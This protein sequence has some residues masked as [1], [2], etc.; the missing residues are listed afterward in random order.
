MPR[1]V[2]SSLRQIL[3]WILFFAFNRLVFILY[4]LR[5]IRAA[6]IS[7][8]EVTQS[9]VAA[10]PLDLST[11][12]YFLII[13]LL[14]LIVQSLFSPPW[15]N[16]LN[17]VYTAI[18]IS[19]YS[20]ITVAEL[21]IYEE[22][23]TKLHYKAL[24][25]LKNPG[26]IYNSAQTGTFFLLLALFAVLLF[27]G[28]LAY[29]RWF[30]RNLVNTGSN[31]LAAALFL[32]IAPVLLFIGMRGGV[33]EIP[34]SQSRSF[35]SR[36]NIMNVA[37]TNSAFNLFISIFENKKYLDKN[38][39][40]FFDQKE[41][42]EIVTGIYQMEHD[43]TVTILSNQRPNIVLVIL[44]SWSADLIESLGGIGGIDP[45][46]EKLVSEGVLFTRVYAPGTRSEQ[47]MA[48]LFG[49]FP[50]H[51]VSSV[52]VQPDKYKDLPSL[53]LSL[54]DQGYY[55]SFYFGGQL[56][57]GNIKSYIYYNGFDRILEVDD[58]PS[59]YQRGKL[60]VHDEFALRKLV[61]DLGSDRQPFFS[62]VFTVSTHSPFDM[63]MKIIDLWEG[64]KYMNLYLNSAFYT[65]RCL[66]EFIGRSKSESWYP[67]TLFVFVADHSHDSYR[68]WPYHSP[69]YHKI[70]LLL[71]GE[72][73]KEEYRGMKVDKL[74]SQ[75]DL[76]ATLL[77][78][79]GLDHHR[80]IWS[81]D[82]LDPGTPG[83]AYVA[84]EEG[85]GWIRPEGYFFYDKPRDHYYCLDIPEEKKETILREGKAF[86]QLVFQD[87]L[88]R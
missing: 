52:T 13:P 17:K 18:M 60:G 2:H 21:G 76:A 58:F 53:V 30:Y 77:A 22:W 25:Y 37:A 55:S 19:L 63:P 34:I 47:G 32:V 61:T 5:E 49:G 72:V 35:Y 27:S 36:H 46:F 43:S 84:F 1:T 62:A 69:E 31:Y 70:P 56:I 9:F 67:N 41:A 79:M 65:D 73:I 68:Q 81:K 12:C 39:Y 66:G 48:S 33:Q 54:R 23:K 11:A 51:P 4:Y 80:F 82:L 45:E 88:D 74:G 6:H 86:L 59:T 26:E 64:D 16:I 14:L 10:F 29:R 3:F 71:F 8:L 87:Y 75:A 78:Q 40:E 50:A 85:I 44:E 15:L 24:L 42:E 20:L 83:F 38:P 57:Y 28:W 7:F